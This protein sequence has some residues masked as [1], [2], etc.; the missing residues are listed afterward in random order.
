MMDLDVL[1][2][3]SLCSR[4]LAADCARKRTFTRVDSFVLGEI[5]S[6]MEFLVTCL[7]H[8][9]LLAFMLPRVT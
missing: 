1:V 4:S 6:P 8:E 2:V 9:F 7:T 5:V 3:I